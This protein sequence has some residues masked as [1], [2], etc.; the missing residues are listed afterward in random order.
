I[1]LHNLILIERNGFALPG[2]SGSLVISASN[3]P[4]GLL[5]AGN[6]NQSLIFPIDRVLNKVNILVPRIDIFTIVGE[7][8]NTDIEMKL[9]KDELNI[10]KDIYNKFKSIKEYLGSGIKIENDIIT[11][12]IF[13]NELN[14]NIHNNKIFK[15]V[16]GGICFP[17]EYVVIEKMFIMN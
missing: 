16:S 13:I 4:V 6:G 14:L 9:D 2:A 17:I 15:N 5:F 8:C 3:F 7:D 12:I 10:G 1:L 11:V